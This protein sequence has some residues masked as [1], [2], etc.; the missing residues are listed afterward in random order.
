MFIDSVKIKFFGGKGGNGLVAWFRAKYLPKGG[1]Y[2]GD[3]G[4]GG[5][6]YLEANENLI[7]LEN[8]SYKKK[9]FAQNGF[10]GGVNNQKGKGGKDLIIKVPIGTIVK[11]NENILFEL[12]KHKE[13]FLLC[14]GGKSGRGNYSFRTATNQAPDI[15]TEG[16]LGEEKD[17]SLDLKLIA[18]IG[19]VGHP[20][21]GKSTLMNK[22]TR[23]KV[24]IA[25]YPFTTLFP[26]IG[27]IEFDDFSRFFLADI[28]GII[29]DAHLNKGLGLSFLKHI[30]RTTVL[31]YVLDVSTED[32]IEDLKILKEEI[33]QFNPEILQKP[34]LIALN[35]IDLIE[36]SILNDL[37]KKLKISEEHLIEISAKDD[38]N[39]EK[40]SS[41]LKTLLQ[42]KGSKSEKTTIK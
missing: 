24:K 23:N 31:L 40:L 37:K 5:S 33:I 15:F 9:I 11:E 39:I 16:K 4:N 28:P 32:P 25:A 19:L 38:L 1:P 7:S 18:D 41:K 20:N 29:K 6:I 13:N 35:K 17:I 10:C 14:K 2:G 22:L 8:F 27:L 21:A 42:N 30:E 12:T 36:P 3:G 34:F 26:N